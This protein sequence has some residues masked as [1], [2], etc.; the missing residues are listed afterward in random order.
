MTREEFMK[1]ARLSA[2]KILEGKENGIMN[3]VH[4]A[5]AE[6]KRNA[7]V[8]TLNKTLKQIV[9][10][11]YTNGT[12]TIE[13]SCEIGYK[14]NIPN[15]DEDCVLLYKGQKIKCKMF[16]VEYADPAWPM[17]TKRV[18]KVCEV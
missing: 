10:E 1:D 7:E 11:A 13:K 15:N 14:D 2:H 6:G 8:E 16:Q 5:W 3:L 18:Y 17:A 12:M 4:Q 9:I